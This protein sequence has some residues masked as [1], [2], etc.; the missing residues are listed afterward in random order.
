MWPCG[1]AV[2]LECRGLRVH[3]PFESHLPLALNRILVVTLPDAYS[4]GV[5]GWTCRPPVSILRFG[6]AACV[7]L[8]DLTHGHQREWCSD[9][10]TSRR[11][12]E[13]LDVCQGR[14]T[15]GYIKEHKWEWEVEEQGLVQSISYLDPVGQWIHFWLSDS[16]LL[17]EDAKP[18]SILSCPA[19]YSSKAA[20]QLWCL[21]TGLMH[22][23]SHLDLLKNS[24]LISDRLTQSCCKNCWLITAARTADSKLLQELLTQNCSKRM[25][26]QERPS[27]ILL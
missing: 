26:N 25:W 1:K 12:E 4:C 24:D 11:G 21:Y 15:Q 16:N 14:R 22:S 7:I 9:A 6:Q 19:A 8:M 3:S 10:M 23:V 18:T 5:C 17:Q 2:C 13:I 20:H 27:T